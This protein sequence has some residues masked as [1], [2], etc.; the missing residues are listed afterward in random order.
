MTGEALPGRPGNL[1]PQEEEKLKEFWVTTLKVFGIIDREAASNGEAETSNGSATP[2]SKTKKKRGFSI[3]RSKHKHDDAASVKSSDS[4]SIS[5]ISADGDDKYGQ[6]KEFHDALASLSPEAIR[7]AFWSMVKYDHPDALLLRFLRA[8]K[9][10]VDKALVMMISTMRWRALD[11]H[12]DDDI[13]K[14]GELA[15]L[16]DEKSTDASKK[17]LGEGFLA[18]MRTG[19]SFLHG[20]DKYVNFRAKILPYLSSAYRTKC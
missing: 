18:Q 2:D 4:N 3:L 6:T 16:E 13:M 7:K 14:N 8:R 11:M 15:A 10:D 5:H 1:T 19:K 9:W 20:H 12:V 17:K